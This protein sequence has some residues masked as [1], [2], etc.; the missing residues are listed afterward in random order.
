M[1]MLLGFFYINKRR[2]K[3]IKAISLNSCGRAMRYTFFFLLETHFQDHVWSYL[4]NYQFLIWFLKLNTFKK[5]EN[6]QIISHKCCLKRKRADWRCFKD[7]Q[8]KK[9]SENYNQ[10]IG[11]LYFSLS[12]NKTE[13]SFMENFI[14]CEIY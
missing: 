14:F 1:L 6:D 10:R 8:N 11:H 9:P 13:N 2:S 3:Q 5:P 4:E 12:C 7:Q